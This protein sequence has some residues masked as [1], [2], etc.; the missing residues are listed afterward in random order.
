MRGYPAGLSE[1]PQPR[2]STASTRRGGQERDEAVVEPQVVREAVQE[3]DRRVVAGMLAD[4]DAVAEMGDGV[5]DG[6][7]P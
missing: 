2:K 7:H 1:A 3:H 5:K 4:V 6:V